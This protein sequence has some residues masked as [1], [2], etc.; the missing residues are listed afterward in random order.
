M[1]DI[2]WLMR[3]GLAMFDTERRLYLGFDLGTRVRL[4]I[5]KLEPFLGVGAYLGD[6][7][8]CEERENAFGDTVEDC[9]KN[10]LGATY[11]EYGLKYEGFALFGREYS[12][13]ESGESLP[14]KRFW[15]I[16]FFF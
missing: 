16:N 11:I 9:E 10:F 1:K 7:K 5:D 2:P 3:L 13:S 15:G 8:R 6:H 12:I 4:K 14:V